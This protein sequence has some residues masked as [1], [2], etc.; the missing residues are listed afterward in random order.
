[1]ISYDRQLQSIVKV[2]A[3]PASPPSDRD[4]AEAVLEASDPESVFWLAVEH[5]MELAHAARSSEVLK[6]ERAA[7]E[8]VMVGP[9]LADKVRQRA[10]RDAEGRRS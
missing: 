7:Q 4:M 3:L 10:D 2:T 5:V 1:M 8:P 6:L 9:E